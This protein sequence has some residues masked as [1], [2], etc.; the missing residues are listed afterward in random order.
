MASELVIMG[1]HARPSFASCWED[2][3]MLFPAKGI[4]L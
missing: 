1:V 4:E 3:R 2:E